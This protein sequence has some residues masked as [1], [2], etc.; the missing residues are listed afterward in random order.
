MARLLC[1][2]RELAQCHPAAVF[3]SLQSFFRWFATGALLDKRKVWREEEQRLVANW[4]SAAERLRAAQ[5]E[6]SRIAVQAEIDT[7]RKRVARIKVEFSSG[8]RY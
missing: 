3:S 2:H 1:Y 7:L 6:A 4:N 5:D 8:K